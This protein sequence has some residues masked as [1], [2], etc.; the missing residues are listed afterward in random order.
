MQAF[1][2]VMCD[3]YCSALKH[4]VHKRGGGVQEFFVEWIYIERKIS[5]VGKFS[6]PEK[7]RWYLMY[8]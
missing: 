5:S 6:I 4:R 3:R 2:N 7:I 8:I 1:F